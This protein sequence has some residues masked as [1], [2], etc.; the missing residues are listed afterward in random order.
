MISGMPN[1]ENEVIEFVLTQLGLPFRPCGLNA[2]WSVSARHL[3]PSNE[4]NRVAGDLYLVDPES[5]TGEYE[6]V[7][8]YPD[9]P[10]SEEEI[11]VVCNGSLVTCAKR[12]ATMLKPVFTDTSRCGCGHFKTDHGSEGCKAL[13]GTCGCGETF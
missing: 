1:Y 10:N 11:E 12:A 8:R 2:D 6:I 7:R 13:A 5:Q 4:P 3:G 9:A